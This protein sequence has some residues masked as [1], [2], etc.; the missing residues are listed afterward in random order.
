VVGDWVALKRGSD[1]DGATIQGVLPR[2]SKFSRKVKGQLTEEQVVSA[3]IDTVFLVNGLDHDFNLRRIERYL[4]LAWESGARPVVILN[5][6]DLCSELEE[7]VRDVE[8]VAIGVP[9]HPLCAREIESLSPLDQYL[10]PG[11][12]AALLG[13]SGVGKSTLINTLLGTE[14]QEVRAIR[15]SDGRGRHTTA[16]RELILLPSRGMIIDNPGM[17]EIQLWGDADALK[18]AF[19]D[20]EELAGACRFRTCRHESEP[21][22][23]V[24]EALEG[25]NLEPRR[26]RSYLKLQKELEHLERRRDQKARRNAKSRWK[27]ITKRIRAMKKDGML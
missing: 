6:A 27:P 9:I 1:N 17:R 21:G 12:T 22:C 16:F 3:N 11:H 19:H 24:R 7:R 26:Y 18:D 25:G 10:Q 14:R 4:A 8:N 13:S 5:K 2:K 23:A 15:E 20:I